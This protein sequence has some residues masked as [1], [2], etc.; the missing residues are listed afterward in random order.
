[1]DYEESNILVRR[2]I[3]HNIRSLRKSRG[4]TQAEFAEQIHV[5]RSY[6]NQTEKGKANVS[7]NKLVRFADGLDVPLTDLFKGV[8]MCAPSGLS[9]EAV[10]A[11]IELPE[12]MDL[13]NLEV[14]D[15]DAGLW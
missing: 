13:E 5:N 11:A 7:V 12:S 8:N 6:V 2:V 10:Y 15:P 3:G 1:M 4:L 9:R 14:D